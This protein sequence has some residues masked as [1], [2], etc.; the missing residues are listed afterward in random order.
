MIPLFL[1]ISEWHYKNIRESVKMA[2]YNYFKKDATICAVSGKTNEL[3]VIGRASRSEQ[4]WKFNN[5]FKCLFPPDT[6]FAV[7]DCIITDTNKYF[8]TAMYRSKDNDIE[9]KM[10]KSNATINVVR[11]IKLYNAS[12]VFTGYSS[13]PTA[14]ATSVSAVHETVTGKMQQF[15]AGLLSTTIAKLT[16]GNIGVALLDRVVMNTISYQVDSINETAIPGLVVIQCSLDKR[17]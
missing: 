7:G 10:T 17:K 5:S 8:I 1:P 9:G 3:I 16:V 14:I 2:V 4:D 6:K 12:G 11:L 13:T 15:D